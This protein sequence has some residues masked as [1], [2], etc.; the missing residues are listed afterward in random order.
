MASDAKAASPQ[1]LSRRELLKRAAIGIAAAAGLGEALR[2]GT[3]GK[4]VAQP[5]ELPE[6]SIFMPRPDQRARVLGK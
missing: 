3:L 1:G 4:P 2:R 6:D 5:L